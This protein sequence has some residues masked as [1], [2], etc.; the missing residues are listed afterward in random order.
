MHKTGG[1]GR[2]KTSNMTPRLRHDQGMLVDACANNT[3]GHSV[4]RV[5]VVHVWE[6]ISGGK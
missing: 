2:G 5:N 4:H 6:E 3:I 1:M